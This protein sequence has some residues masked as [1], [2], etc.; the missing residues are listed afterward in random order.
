MVT[1]SPC[2]ECGD[3]LEWSCGQ[4]T[5]GDIL[6]WSRSARC[7]SCGVAMEIDGEGFPPEDIARTMILR[8]GIWQ[9]HLEDPE[10][11]LRAVQALRQLLGFDLAEAARMLRQR[12]QA[13][14]SGT[15]AEV[16]WIQGRLRRRGVESGVEQGA[17][18]DD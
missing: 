6:C 1:D 11:Q 12:G 5:D 2:P 15:H 3:A 13:L 18:S 17:E 9:L 14:W 10:D 16:C 7:A 4:Y 8:S